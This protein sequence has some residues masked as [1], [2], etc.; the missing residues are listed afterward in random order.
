MG[1]VRAPVLVL[2]C[3]GFAGLAGC[4]GQSGG[5]DGGPVTMQFTAPTAGAAFTRD[6]LGATG[7][8]VALVDVQLAIDGEPARVSLGTGGVELVDAD[9]AGHAV[10]PVPAA[11]T[12]TL[13]A[14]AYDAD[15]AVVAQAM[16][17]I[18]IGEPAAADCH[19]W[20]D[21]YQVA[22][23]L[24]PNNEGV[25]DPVTATVPINGVEY[26]YVENTNPRATM[27]ADC[28]LI[29]SLAKAAPIMRARGIVE[30][31]DI[32]I[33]NYRCIG[34]GTPPD[35][36]NGISQHAYAKA[37]DLAGF[38]DGAGEYASVLDDWVIDPSGEATCA[39]AT[40]PGKDAFLHELIC[41]LKARAIWNIVLTP[42]YNA[43]HRNH[44]HVDL[45]PDDDFIRGRGTV[46]RGP[47]HH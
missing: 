17:D 27:F 44:F 34:G 29:L 16:V 39:A 38:T 40:E 10:V 45:T 1:L 33:Y 35:C 42:N 20:L 47:D 18:Q 31:A 12:V 3:A 13:T 41:E 23:T 22:F 15:A 37:I 46:D 26:R 5:D 24:G 36:P 2:V 43:D 21:L 8:L 9:A 19:A 32:G 30:V 6:Q 25:G 7:D 14:L 4:T 11:G 28:E